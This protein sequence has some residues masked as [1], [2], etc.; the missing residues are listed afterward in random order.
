MVHNVTRFTRPLGRC[1]V[2][3]RIDSILRRSHSA[4]RPRTISKGAMNSKNDSLQT[5]ITDRA[6]IDF[7]DVRNALREHY[8]IHAVELAALGGD[9]DHNIRV[10][11]AQLRRFVV[12]LAPQ[13]FST[14]TL[15]W[16]EAVLTHLAKREL[17]VDVP[18][19]VPTSTG[20]AHCIAVVGG[21]A[22][23]MRVVN[24]VEGQ[25]LCAN[26]EHP[27]GLLRDLGRTAAE[28]TLALTGLVRPMNPDTDYWMLARSHDAVRES[29]GYVR[30]A[31]CARDVEHIME[32]FLDCESHFQALPLATVHQ[33][34]NDFNI[35]VSSPEAPER[36]VT[37][38]I[39]FNDAG[40]TIRVAEP[41]VAAAYAML[42]KSD[43]LSAAAE[44]TAGYNEVLPLTEN[45]LRVLFPLAAAR[46][47]VNATTW[48][49]RTALEDD[50]YGETRMSKTWATIAKVA[51]VNPEA[52][53]AKLRHACG[54]P[55]RQ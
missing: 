34:L 37:G 40:T 24:W 41:A 44:V 17:P 7:D 38:V 22:H 52:A 25:L 16:Q 48:T 6:V 21:E 2:R 4:Q 33:D 11:D 46:L 18:S 9:A 19:I 54:L 3:P 30:D 10:Q 51:T 20:K 31:D 5:S 43:P 23:L 32:G 29:I 35:L 14:D 8:N 47:C 1:P 28:I 49:K 55:A 53:E 27:A 15:R 12:K 26:D 42:G 13:S 36:R 45:E 39:D 50:A